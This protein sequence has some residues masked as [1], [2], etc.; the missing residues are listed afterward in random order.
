M[1]MN[2]FE[3]LSVGIGI[4]TAIVATVAFIFS[5]ARSYRLSVESEQRDWAKSSIIGI[6]ETNETLNF[7]QLFS[8]YTKTGVD[9]GRRGIS[10]RN[11]RRSLLGL[12]ETDVIAYNENATY[13]LKREAL[14]RGSSEEEERQAEVIQK[15]IQGSTVS[16]AQPKKA[17]DIVFRMEDHIRHVVNSSNGKF[18]QDELAAQ[19]SRYFDDSDFGFR[20]YARHIGKMLDVNML[21]TDKDRRIW[22]Y[23]I[24]K[25]A[26]FGAAAEMSSELTTDLDNDSKTESD[27]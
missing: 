11:L 25:L 1:S 12:M 17:E 19:L 8:E 15:A 2:R 22:N 6:F 9:Q 14:F 21:H 16:D 10:R 13:F 23:D 3:K 27:P 5:T 18:T 4:S 7:E 24:T 20:D 26:S